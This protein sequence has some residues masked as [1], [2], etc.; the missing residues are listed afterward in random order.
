MPYVNDTART[1]QF[2]VGSST[3]GASAGGGIVAVVNGQ[4]FPYTW[5]YSGHVGVSSGVHTVPPGGTYYAY[6]VGSVY[7][8]APYV[9]WKELR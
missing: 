1:I 6:T 5:A 2:V 4:A 9:S 3:G 7:G 8:G